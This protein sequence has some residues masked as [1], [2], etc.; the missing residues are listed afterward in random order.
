MASRWELMDLSSLEYDTQRGVTLA[1]SGAGPPVSTNTSPA[2][3]FGWAHMG[4]NAYDLNVLGTS[5]CSA[6]T[7]GTSTGFG[8]VL[9]LDGTWGAPSGSPNPWNLAL[10][11]C[12][13]ANRVWCIED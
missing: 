10:H 9:L 3:A 4:T 7:N 6:W 12:S 11:I 8:P 1:D 13:N 2:V 5:N